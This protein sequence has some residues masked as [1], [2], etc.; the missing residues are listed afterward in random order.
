MATQTLVVTNAH[1]VAGQHDTRVRTPGHQR[2]D[3]ELVYLDTTNDIAVLH[4]PGLDA[5][6]LT[7]AERGR[8]GETVV[9]LGYPRGGPL[10]ADYATAGRATKVLAPDALNRSRG[11]RTVVPIRATVEPGESGGP[12]VNADG[13]VVSMVFG[14]TQDTEGSVGV[15]LAA[16]RDALAS[17]LRRV[18]AGTCVR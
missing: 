1:V 15:P 17:D 9:L 16:L 10:Q 6:S 12:I 18:P 5:P 4:V 14:A 3:A 13:H 2:L 8:H 7:L 11:F